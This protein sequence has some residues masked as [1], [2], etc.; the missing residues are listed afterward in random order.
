MQTVTTSGFLSAIL[1]RQRRLGLIALI[2][3]LP[4]ALSCFGSFPLTKTVLDGN[5]NVN[6]SVGA[7]RTQR[8]LAQSAVMWLFIPVYAV[9]IIG[10]SLVF[11]LIEFWTGKTTN[12]SYGSY[13]HGNAVA[14]ES[15]KDGKE[16]TLTI[17]R[18]G[19]VIVRQQYVKVGENAFEVRDAQNHN[20]VIGM[21]V[22]TPLG[23]LNLK[24]ANGNTLKTISPGAMATV[25]E[26]ED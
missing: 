2:A 9:T 10:D 14:L 3:T 13:K 26:P 18:E 23:T 17:A 22:R 5:R 1:R 20:R 6:S 7:D 12:V 4:L 8:K 16:A 19:K 15:T 11:N 24:D 21:V 25:P